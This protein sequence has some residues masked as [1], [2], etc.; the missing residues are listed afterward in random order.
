VDP[1]TLLDRFG[2]RPKLPAD[3]ASALG[4]LDRLARDRPELAGPA[5]GLARLLGAAFSPPDS[6]PLAPPDDE[7]IARGWSEGVPACRSDPPRLDDRALID[8]A[9]SLASAVGTDDPAA[10]ALSEAIRKRRIDLP[11]L[12]RE[13]F[14]GRPEEVARSAESA[15]VSPVLTA[16]LLRLAILP[17]LARWSSALDRI[18]PEGAW[19]R[20]DCPDCGSRLL[21]AESRGLEQR[22]A[23]RC[24]LCAADWPGERLRCPSCGESSPKRLR[25]S[26]IE[27]EQ[28]R[29]RLAACEACSDHWKVVATLGPLSPP[30]LLVADLA[31]F[32]LDV[33]AEGRD[34]PDG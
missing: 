17:S 13:V 10:P 5:R 22:I 2:R 16:S 34:E 33:L 12:A 31:T 11:A 28:E 1:R 9:R 14:A 20:G 18:R 6:A 24:G 30:G 27:G 4:D 25:I 21:L 15:G 23:Y 8:R 29:Y 19:D 7:A 32:H 26:F 3:L